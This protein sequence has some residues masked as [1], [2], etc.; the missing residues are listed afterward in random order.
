MFPTIEIGPL[1]LSTYAV[2]YGLAI[3]VGGM[4]G[5][6]RLIQGGSPAHHATWG[7]L[8]TVW[9]ALAG[10]FM[11]RHFIGALIG[12][13]I[14]LLLYCWRYGFPLGRV[15]DFGCLSFPLALAIGRL[16]CFAAG[17]CYGRPTDSW[18]GMYLPDVHGVWMVRYPTQLMSSAANFLMFVGLLA[19]ERYGTRRQGNLK[20]DVPS[21]SSGQALS[22]PKGWPFDGFLFLLYVDLYCLKRFSIEFLRG[23]AMPVIGSFT[24][25]QIAC[26]VVFLLST[27][28]MLRGL[29]STAPSSHSVAL[30]PPV[31][32]GQDRSR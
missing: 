24:L 22:L 21:T 6:H 32:G 2:I 5:F 15:S 20:S 12:G 11:G 3:I 28:L 25:T 27:A 9:G 8:L 30:S 31:A 29:R 23:D 13:G 17:C 1:H 10:V 4:V 14:V 16:G 7:T 26:L 19:F 18:L